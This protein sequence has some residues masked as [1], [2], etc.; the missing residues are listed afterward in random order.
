MSEPQQ[1]PQQPQPTPPA[2]PGEQLI[3]NSPDE[4]R[5]LK[6]FALWAGVILL[7][8]MTAYSFCLHGSFLWDDDRHVEQ[9]RGLRDAEGLGNIWTG[10]WRYL[11]ASPEQRQQIRVYT[12]QYYPMTHTS[13]WLEYQ[14]S[15]SQPNDINTTVFHVDNVLL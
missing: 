12:P 1:D 7:L 14:F 5:T 13:Y 2:S 15:G 10:H 11:F 4:A 6:D 9:N 8:T 3:L